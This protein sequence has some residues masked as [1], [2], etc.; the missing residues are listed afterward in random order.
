MSEPQ[1][2]ETFMRNYQ[3]MVY[4]TAIRLLGNAA[5]AED[6]AQDAFLRAYEHFDQIG[7]SPHAGGWLKTVTTRLCLTQ[8]ARRASRGRSFSELGDGSAGLGEVPAGDVVSSATASGAAS[9]EAIENALH[10]LPDDQRVPLVLYH[11][12]ARRYEEIA[13]LLNVSIGKVKTDIHR[14]RLALRRMIPN[15]GATSSS[16]DP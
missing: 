6:A 12:E 3:D 15:V 8:L 13:G 7:S 14:G 10:R 2:F 16:D 9:R 1:Q 4:A 5:D 11:F